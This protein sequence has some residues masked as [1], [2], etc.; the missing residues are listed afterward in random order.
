VI[1]AININGRY[2]N[3]MPLKGSFDVFDLPELILALNRQKRTGVLTIENDN[4]TYTISFLNGTIV[5]ARSQ[6][7]SGEDALYECFLLPYAKFEYN[8]V[9]V[10]SDRNIQESTMVIIVQ[11]VDL[12][13]E[14]KKLEQIIDSKLWKL[15]DEVQSESISLNKNDFKVLFLLQDE[16]KLK[17]VIQD[18]GVRNAISSLR[19]LIQIGVLI[20]TKSD[21]VQEEQNIQTI[22]EVKKT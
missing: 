9:E 22:Q 13:E 20:T 6:Y 7:K 12:K 17:E 1:F 2:L 21:E 4:E 10:L 5:S 11:G 14:Y 19:K 16:K 8:D 18:V 3:F 15:N